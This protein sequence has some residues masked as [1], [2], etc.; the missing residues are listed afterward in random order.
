MSVSTPEGIDLDLALAGL[1]SRVSAAAIDSAIRG[2]LYIT[3]YY[4]IFRVGTDLGLGGWTIAIFLPLLFAVELGYDVVFETLASGRTPGKRLNGLRVLL[5]DGRPVDLRSSAVRNVLRLI[6]GVGTIFIAGT[7]SILATERNQRLGDLAASTVV[8]RE[9]RS[10]VKTALPAA[11]DQHPLPPNVSAWDVSAITPSE[12][13]AVRAFLDRRDS[14]ERTH[15]DRIALELASRL[16]AKAI[17]ATG[18]MHPEAFL[19]A[20]RLA[21][22][23]RD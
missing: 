19:E 1:G 3:M 9:R 4:V 23:L 11:F 15:R 22:T 7:I 6:D 21:K 10:T 17:G 12:V 5:A 8:V 20:I 16:R 13:G 2:L 18:Q 14:L